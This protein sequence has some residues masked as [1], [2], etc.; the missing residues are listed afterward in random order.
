[1]S[2]KSRNYGHYGHATYE[3]ERSRKEEY[4]YGNT[5]RKLEPQRRLDETPVKKQ[6]PEV[7]KNREKAKYMNAGYALFLTGALCIVV[8]ILVNYVQ[9]D[10]ELRTLTKTVA[11]KESSLNNLRLSNDEEYNRIINSIDLEEIKRIAMGELGMIY[12][13]EGQ[14]VI[15]ESESRDY[16]RQ[17]TGGSQ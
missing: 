8:A 15:Y 4:I 6:H 10:A 3:K 2:Q 9:M 1:M 11:A 5:V 17:V 12:A 14:V 7:R 13:Q 16:M